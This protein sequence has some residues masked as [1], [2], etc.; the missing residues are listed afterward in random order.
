[1]APGKRREL[2][3]RGASWRLEGPV[4]RAEGPPGGVKVAPK[5][6]IL[7]RGAKQR[8]EGDPRVWRGPP[9][10]GGLGLEG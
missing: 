5:N 3:G 2:E 8:V 7:E 10:G 6:R 4:Q 1:M 9:D